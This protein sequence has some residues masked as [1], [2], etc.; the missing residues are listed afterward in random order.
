MRGEHQCLWLAPPIGW[1]DSWPPASTE[2]D[3]NSQGWTQSLWSRAWREGAETAGLRRS[4][5]IPR[6]HVLT[7]N[8]GKGGTATLHFGTSLLDG[9]W[10]HRPSAMSGAFQGG[11]GVE[12]G[13]Q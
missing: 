4:S 3:A 1:G 10:W 2:A 6:L 7:M 12:E 5:L 9:G 13:T 8:F 11:S